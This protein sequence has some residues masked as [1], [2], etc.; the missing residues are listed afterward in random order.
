MFIFVC[1]CFIFNLSC[2]QV[3]CFPLIYFT[4]VPCV[5]FF[6]FYFHLF[7]FVM[8][9]IFH[10]CQKFKLSLER[11]KSII[12]SWMRRKEIV[13]NPLQ[14][15]LTLAIS[16]FKHAISNTRMLI[17]TCF[18]FT[19][20]LHLVPS[21]SPR[22]GNKRVSRDT[23]TLMASSK[24]KSV[25]MSRPVIPKSYF[26]LVIALGYRLGMNSLPI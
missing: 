17:L 14:C 7:R 10:F 22:Q 11:R 25:N 19:L 8:I 16:G 21:I 1:L 20:Y 18:S 12:S 6:V 9:L 15:L 23:N 26:F 2:F 3:H 4:I 5:I 13:W 24:Q